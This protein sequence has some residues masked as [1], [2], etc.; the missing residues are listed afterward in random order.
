MEA[1]FTKVLA[2]LKREIHGSNGAIH[3]SSAGIDSF[4]KEYSQLHFAIARTHDWP[5]WNTGQ[6]CIDTHF[7]FPLEHL[8][9]KDPANYVFGPTDEIIS[10]YTRLGETVLYRLGT[11]IEHSDVHFNALMPKDFDH[12]AEILAGIVRHYTRGWANGFRYNMMFEIWNEADLGAKMWSGSLP[13]FEQ[14]FATVLARLKREFP[15]VVIGGPAYT[16]HYTVYLENLLNACKAREVAPDFISWHT[17]AYTPDYVMEQTNIVRKLL[18]DNGFKNTKTCLDEW[19]YLES[20][21]G[22]SQN[23]TPENRLK[24]I[25]TLHSAKSAVFNLAV[26]AGWQTAPM[27]MACYYGASPNGTWGYRNAKL[28]LDK[29]YYSMKLYGELLQE[30]QLRTA[31]HDDD[32]ELYTLAATTEDH[33]RQAL[34]IAD[35]NAKLP[36]FQAKVTGLPTHVQVTALIL[37]E[38]H[39]LAEVPVV[40]NG[41]LLTVAHRN[42]GPTACLM[43]MSNEPGVLPG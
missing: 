31:S 4:E 8:D 32:S 28:Q 7:V 13:E 15:D 9:P 5:L 41:D 3:F 43:Q 22:L 17:Y 35:W 37:D 20:W 14:F 33:G 36:Q 26:L 10:R 29:N 19:H 23:T 27:D 16:T 2:P 12:Y 39:D 40:R 34:L 24:A 38:A 42:H 18:D 11:S 21:D 30:Y 1:D 25:A 6:R